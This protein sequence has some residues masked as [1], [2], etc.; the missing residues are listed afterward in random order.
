VP[1]ALELSALDH[2][3]IDL[4]PYL[5]L[6]AD[7]EEKLASIAGDAFDGVERPGARASLTSMLE[8][9]TD[10]KQRAQILATIEAIT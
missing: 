2:A 3:G 4:E 8:V 10:A 6:L 7:M 1:R 5:A 9:T